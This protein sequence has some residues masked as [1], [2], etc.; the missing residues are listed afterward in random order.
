MTKKSP[1]IGG[2]CAQLFLFNVFRK[3]CKQQQK[4][5]YKHIKEIRISAQICPN[6]NALILIYFMNEIM[7]VRLLVQFRSIAGK[8]VLH[9]FPAFLICHLFLYVADRAHEDDEKMGVAAAKEEKNGMKSRFKGDTKSP[10]TDSS[11][12][13]RSI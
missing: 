11:A 13:V 4:W 2:K 9:I 3:L 1:E 10:I 8:L 12:E 5:I 6:V 7:V